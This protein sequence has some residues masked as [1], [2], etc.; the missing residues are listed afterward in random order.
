MQDV[1]ELPPGHFGPG[2]TQESRTLSGKALRANPRNAPKKVL[3]SCRDRSLLSVPRAVS[4][5][6]HETI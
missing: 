2:K 3:F 5:E 6:S 1:Q 4:L